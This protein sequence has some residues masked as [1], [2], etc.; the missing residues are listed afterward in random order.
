[1]R[2]RMRPP[3]LAPVLLIELLGPTPWDRQ[4]R[5]FFPCLNAGNLHDLSDMVAGMPQR[6]LK[7][8]RHG[9][10]LSPDQ[11]RFA[12]VL[13]LEASERFQQAGPAAFPEFQEFRPT[14]E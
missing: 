1:M 3:T 13:R 2:L 10:R 14:G 5:P 12:E 6:A 11:D 8:Q 4:R 7:G 9:M